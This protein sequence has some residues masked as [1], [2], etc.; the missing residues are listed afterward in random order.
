MCA[1]NPGLKIGPYVHLMVKDGGHGIEAALIDKIFDPFFTTKRHQG[2]TGLGLSVVYGIVR[3]CD[4]VIQVKSDPG[5]G[6]TFNIYI[7]STEDMKVAEERKVMPAIP[8]GRETI[9]LVD[10][11]ELLVQAMEKYLQALGYDAVS[12]TS[13]PDALYMVR[14]N[15]RRFD[16]MI[17]DMTMPHMTGLKLSRKILAINPEIPIVL[18]TGYNES[19]TEVEAKKNGIREFVLKPITL[20]KM[21]RLVRQVLDRP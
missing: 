1:I 11:E 8:R 2:G 7:P 18:C 12:L 21:A 5:Q 15:P 14:E 17:T 4:G 16:L 6:T 9:L 20:Q 13:S 19:I 3:R 10:D